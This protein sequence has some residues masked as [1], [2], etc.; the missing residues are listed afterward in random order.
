[1]EKGTAGNE[2]GR[3]LKDLLR[4]PAV[5]FRQ[6]VDQSGAALVL[7]EIGCL[8]VHIQMKILPR[9]DEMLRQDALNR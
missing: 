9:S 8:G 6:S 7:S 1:M 5:R 3:I 2:K 4:P